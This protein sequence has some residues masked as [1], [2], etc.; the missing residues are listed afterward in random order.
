MAA[1]TSQLPSLNVTGGV[2][3]ELPGGQLATE[4][5][6]GLPSVSGGE[7]PTQSVTAMFARLQEMQSQASTKHTSTKDMQHYLKQ[8]EN[9]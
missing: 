6:W 3:N 1:Q 4:S 7:H 5:I 2:V 8:H 9:Q